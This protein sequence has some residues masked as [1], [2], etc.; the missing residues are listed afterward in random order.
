M[1][2]LLDEP[3]VGVMSDLDARSKNTTLEEGGSVELPS[4]PVLG[5]LKNARRYTPGVFC[6]EFETY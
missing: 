1:A 4:D 2:E 3:G 5:S 6:K